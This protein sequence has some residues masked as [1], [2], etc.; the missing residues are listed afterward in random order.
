MANIKDYLSQILKA[1]YGKDVR[2]SIHDAIHQCYEDGKAGATDLEA[3]ELIENRVG[4]PDYSKLE[5]LF[6]V[7]FEQ[8]HSEQWGVYVE[9]DGFVYLRYEGSF[10][11]GAGEPNYSHAQLYINNVGVFTVGETMDT[12]YYRGS[13]SLY[14]VKAGDFVKVQSSSGNQ[15][16]CYCHFFPLRKFEESNT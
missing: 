7:G 1:R 11:D 3:R 2:Q 4:F 10:L 16:T 6:T 5:T 13:S 9:G 12:E 15:T 14:P 8:E